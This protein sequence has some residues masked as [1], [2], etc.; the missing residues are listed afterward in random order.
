[1]AKT[2]PSDA[3][4][5]AE[6]PPGWGSVQSIVQIGE[7]SA[8][9]CPAADGGFCGSAGCDDRK[10]AL[11]PP[12]LGVAELRRVGAE[13]SRAILGHGAAETTPLDLAGERRMVPAE[14]DASIAVV[15]RPQRPRFGR[16]AN[17][18]RRGQL[19]DLLRREAGGQRGA[20][21]GR[22]SLDGSLERLEQ[23][24]SEQYGLDGTFGH[25]LFGPD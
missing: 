1:V 10:P 22:M 12:Q 21:L 20:E 15:P 17:T 11:G 23:R 13:V 14:D 16:K 19:V 3:Q 7:A 6:G 2:W 24:F 9:H 4:V 8:F 18:E 5:G 25:Y